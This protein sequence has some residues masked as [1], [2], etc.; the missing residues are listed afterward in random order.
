MRAFYLIIGLGGLV[1]ISFGIPSLISEYKTQK[2]GTIVTVLLTKVPQ[3]KGFAEFEFKGNIYSKKVDAA[4]HKHYQAG[5]LL[6][7]KH[8]AGSKQFLFEKEKVEGDLISI[9]IFVLVCLLLVIKGLR[10]KTETK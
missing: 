1:F 10:T 3:G 5:E 7:M 2:E 9:G 8:L 4:F 6:K